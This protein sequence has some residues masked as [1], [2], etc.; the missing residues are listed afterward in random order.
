VSP[1]R[2]V[3]WHDVECGAYAADLPLWRELAAE[4]DGPV[5]DVGAGTGRVAL[6]LARQGHAVT[7]LDND[8]DLL[9]ELR[10]HAG[11]LPVEAVEADARDF[12][13]E[14]RFALVIVPMQT[15]QILGGPDARAGFLSSARAHLD[16]GA[17]LVASVTEEALAF[18]PHE[19]I[20]L[21]LPDMAE[22][23]GWV[24]ASQPVTLRGDADGVV[25]ERLRV[26]VSPDGER[27]EERNEV[28]LESLDPGTLAAE[29]EPL[30]FEPLPPRHIPET[31]DHVGSAVAVLRAR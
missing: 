12:S 1:P 5:L 11:D 18:E 10:R 15:I 24:Y 2:E 6:D 30:G 25:I 23:D 27:S 13:L 31:D 17:L 16:P 19:Q 3:I 9:E 7:A 21:P 26:T 22:H 28:R 4:A 14:R 8:G 20:I 29:A